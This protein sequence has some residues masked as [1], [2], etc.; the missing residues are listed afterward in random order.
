MKILCWNTDETVWSHWV[1]VIEPNEHLVRGVSF[2]ALA[3][4]LANAESVTDYCFIYIEDT[5]FTEMVEHAVSIR[6]QYPTLKLIVFPHQH[7]QTA[8]LRLLSQGVNGQCNPYIGAEQ[9]KLVLSV[10]SAGEIWGG[11]AFIEQLISQ[12]ADKVDLEQVDGDARL[13]T[14]TEREKGVAEWVSKGLNNKLVASKMQITERTVKAHLTAIFKKTAT[15][16]RLSLALLVQ[17]SH[18]V[19]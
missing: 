12:S 3:S 19:H 4:E 8:A 9:L 6:K 16:D 17:N 18:T 14:L 1:K 2:D 7:S 10:V 13:A 5:R 11:K 15:K